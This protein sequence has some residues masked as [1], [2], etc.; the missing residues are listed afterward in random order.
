MKTLE[1]KYKEATILTGIVE[2]SVEEL[3]EKLEN[4]H[5][6]KQEFLRF[7]NEKR[8]KEFLAARIL[9]NIIAG[10]HVEVYYD[11]QKKPFLRDEAFQISISHSKNHIAVIA[12]PT[13]PVGIDIE[14]RTD[15]VKNVSKRFLGE[16]ELA[17]FSKENNTDKLEIAWSA[18]ETLY[19]IIGNE[20][21]DFAA[22]LEIFPFSLNESGAIRV[23]HV[24]GSRMYELHYFQNEIYTLV[25][26]VDKKIRL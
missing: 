18:K 20:A 16:E 3:I 2:E 11:E 9:L 12:H 1:L 14:V 24:S 8:R 4:F 19:K 13:C 5:T 15:R 6:Y 22:E 7:T 23:L 21:R 25:F 26:G 17:F 10:K